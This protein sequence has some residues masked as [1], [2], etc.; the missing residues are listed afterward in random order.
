MARHFRERGHT[1]RF[2]EY[3][4]VG[5]TNG[6]RMDDVVP[7]AEIVA[8]LDEEFGVEPLEPTYRGE[9]ARRWRYRDGRGEV[10][11][12]ASVTQPFCGDCTRAR[13]SAEG[14]STR[15]SSPSAATTSGRSCAPARP[16]TSSLEA[17]AGDLVAARR[18]LL[19]AAIGRDRRPA[20]GR[21]ELHRRL[22]ALPGRAIR[23]RRRRIYN[24]GVPAMAAAAGRHLPRGWRDL[25]LQIAIWFGFLAA[26]QVARGL[27]DR[28]AGEAV[29][30]GLRVVRFETHSPAASWSSGLQQFVEAK[31]WLAPLVVVDVLELRVHGARARAALALPAAPRVLHAL[32]EH[33]PARERASG[34]WATSRC[35]WRRRGSSASGSPT[36]TSDGL[37][38]LAANP[39]AAM[40]SLH[41]ADALILGVV[42]AFVCRHRLAKAFWIAWPA[43]VW[44]AV[45]A[46]GNHFWLDCIAGMAVALVA[47]AVVY[48]RDVCA[49]LAAQRR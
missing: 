1:L 32:P 35:R 21:D 2:I 17:V 22:T 23:R 48:R 4:D 39:Y 15:A 14:R 43:W 28:T 5:H 41:A 25:G 10:G 36:S 11:V 3:M 16:T 29:A 24:R 40:P 30:N 13:I 45:M 9:V 31:D 47:L 38:T 49:A 18:P 6:W 12:I 27:A 8:A 44:F 37:V 7:A 34:S 42:L 19:R 33:D 26:Y 46:T 20:E